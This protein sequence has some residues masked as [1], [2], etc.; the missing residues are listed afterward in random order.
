MRDRSREGLRRGLFREVATAGRE[1][2]EDAEDRPLLI[3]EEA[4]EVVPG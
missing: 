1:R 3:S 4:A 2:V